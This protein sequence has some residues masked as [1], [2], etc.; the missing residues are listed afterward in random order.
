MRGFWFRR[1][2]IL[3]LHWSSFCAAQKNETT[4]QVSGKSGSKFK[5]IIRFD[6]SFNTNIC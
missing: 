2:V 3:L 6:T 5:K 4:Q 1:L